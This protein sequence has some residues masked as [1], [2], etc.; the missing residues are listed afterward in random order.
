MDEQLTSKVPMIGL[1]K[2]LSLYLPLILLSSLLIFSI[3]SGTLQKFLFYLVTILLL[4]ILR[5]I[6]FKASGSEKKIIN[7]TKLP[8][9][10]S[11]GLINTF[12]PQDVLF[13]TYL[14]SFTLFYFLTPMILLSIDSNVNSINYIIVLFF[15]CYIFLDLSMK[16]QMGCMTNIT[17]VGIAGN[18][19]SGTLLGAGLSALLYTSSVKNLLYINEVNSDNEVC[20]MPSQQ[21]FKCRVYKNG[22]LVG[23]TIS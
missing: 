22:E 6:V 11:I 10:C 18:L 7:D 9:D 23:S 19:F 5:L 16:K 13:G 21:K 15:A 4:I 17:N 20:S 2:S 12:I 3:L 8:D 1:F 14:L